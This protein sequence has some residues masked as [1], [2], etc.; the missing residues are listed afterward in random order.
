MKIIRIISRWF[1]G[2][3]FIF[4]GFVK[5]IDPLGTAFQIED[6]LVAYSLDGFIPLSLSLSV[7]LC[8]F[9]FSL[10]V[11]LILN[12]KPKLTYW[13]LLFIMSFFTLITFYDAIYEPVPDCGCFGDAIKLTNWQTFY[14][15]IVLMVPTLI[16]FRHR[17]KAKSSWNLFLEY[18]MIIFIFAGFAWFSV[19]N[20]R[21]LPMIDFLAWKVGNKVVSESKEPLQFFLT[22]R[23]KQTGETKQYLSPNFPYNDS[24]WMTQWE[25]VSQ[26]VVDPNPR[27]KHNLQIFDSKSNDMTG[28][29]L[30]NPEYQFLLVVWKPEKADTSALKKMNE[31]YT[32]VSHDGYSF[33]AIAP[34]IEAGKQL[35]A[36]LQLN[37][38][39]YYADDVELKIMVRANPG[40]ILLKNGQVIAKWSHYNFIDYQEV[41][42]FLN[43]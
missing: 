27:P 38:E 10:G 40:L 7:L 34:T 19:F 31:L 25:F 9:E 4:S 41:R 22:Y 8:A 43:D 14:K 20:Y 5:G 42:N 26:C 12:V 13:A 2:L 35:S 28:A 18:A 36:N 11:F 32:Q 1:V 29:F 6:Y 30:N 3:V 21:N 24:V 16:L 39:F 17:K 33:I 15:N 37:Y 23:N